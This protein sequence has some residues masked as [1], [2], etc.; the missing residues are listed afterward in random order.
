MVGILAGFFLGAV[1]ALYSVWVGLRWA[2]E[3]KRSLPVSEPVEVPRPSGGG[4]AEA[5]RLLRE[6]MLGHEEEE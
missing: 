2:Q 1:L 4:G 5:R 6:W 3:I